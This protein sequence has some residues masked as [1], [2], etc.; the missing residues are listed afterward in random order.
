M[1]L[2]R[3]AAVLFAS[4]LVAG[5]V[6]AQ[7]PTPA[8]PFA[9]DDRA[10]RVAERYQSMLA[11]NPAEGMALDRLWKM[12]EERNATVLLIDAYRRA[13]DTSD[14][15]AD[16]LIYGNLL[17]R[18]GRLD[19]AAGSY[20]RASRLDPASPL[21]LVAQADLAIGRSQPGEAAALLEK[22]LAIVPP[23]DRRR[24][25]LLLKLGDTW[26]AAGQ[27]LK[28]GEVWEM[29][30]ATDPANLALRKQLAAN[31]EKNGLPER[32][33]VHYEY[34]DQHADPPRRAAALRELGRLARNTRRVRRRA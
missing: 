7:L 28:A 26:L 10:A 20:A 17:K 30:V 14:K 2:P 12:Y 29:L 16:A 4:F 8:A 9:D 32:A 6:A 21:P 23:L 11:A 15:P 5:F 19:E 27:P 25:D 3:C 33:I 18:A 34:I 22:A 1:T 13:A 31:Y 24:T